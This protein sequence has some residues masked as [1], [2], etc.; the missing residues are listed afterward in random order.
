MVQITYTIS[1]ISGNILCGPG[2]HH[3]KLTKVV[4]RKEWHLWTW[5]ST[6]NRR[7]SLCLLALSKNCNKIQSNNV[8]NNIIISLH[9]TVGSTKGHVNGAQN[10]QAQKEK[11]RAFAIYD[12]SRADFIKGEHDCFSIN[13][14][15]NVWSCHF[16][17]FA[18]MRTKRC[19]IKI[20]KGSDGLRMVEKVLQFY[21]H[22][23]C[24]TWPF[25]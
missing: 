21:S 14:P 8:H 4:P 5:V 20:E 25:L 13:L 10:L 16:Q 3:T 7:T 22:L 9:S 19:S 23:M 17:H 15:Y 2:K 11:V 24:E 12:R 1:S 18:F 6:T